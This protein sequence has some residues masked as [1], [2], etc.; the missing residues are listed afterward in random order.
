MGEEISADNILGPGTY[1]TLTTSKLQ[2]K[3]VYFMIYKEC[4]TLYQA[5][6]FFGAGKNF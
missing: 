6:H 4:S 3:C 5:L 2:G 1:K